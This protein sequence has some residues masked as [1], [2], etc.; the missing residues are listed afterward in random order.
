MKG[1]DYGPCKAMV[2]R[3]SDGTPWIHSFAHGRTVYELKYDTSCDRGGDHGRRRGSC[4][5]RYRSLRMIFQ[6]EINRTDED[7]LIGL[8]AKRAKVR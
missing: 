7:S 5:G 8:A 2:M 1:S 6:G 3:R 4:R